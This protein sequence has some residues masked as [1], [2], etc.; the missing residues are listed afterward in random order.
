[1]KNKTQSKAIRNITDTKYTLMER[2]Y[3]KPEKEPVSQDTIDRK[4]LQ[5][6]IEKSI[7]EGYNDEDIKVVLEMKYPKYKDFLDVWI[8]NKRKQFSSSKSDRDDK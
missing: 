8:S 3:K 5:A 2:N 1:M 4:N 7:K 6:F